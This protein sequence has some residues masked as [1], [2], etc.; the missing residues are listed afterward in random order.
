MPLEAAPDTAAVMDMM[1]KPLET[2]LLARAR[3]L[4]MS[5]VDG[6]AM[7]IGQAKPSFEAFF[8]VAPP[9][10]VDVRVLLQGTLR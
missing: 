6:L 4:G 10:A 3:A 8:G 7:L 9:A 2:P 5:T 1:Y